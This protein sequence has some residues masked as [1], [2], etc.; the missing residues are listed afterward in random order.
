MKTR[1]TIISLILL[2]NLGCSDEQLDV[3]SFVD[4]QSITTLNGQ[5]KVFSFENYTN[6]IREFKTQTNSNGFDIIINFDES[7]SPKELFGRNT[8]NTMEGEFE[9]IGVRKIRI[10]SY[11]STRV[12]QPAWADQF[13]GA[14]SDGEVTF[15][16]NAANLRI[17]YS[18]NTK[19]VTLKRE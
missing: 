10:S 13:D 19:S 18:N 12:A 16:I 7:K 6:N 9:Y 15:K 2:V 4:D 3:N 14:I 5:W 1:I 17:Y 8:T 11:I